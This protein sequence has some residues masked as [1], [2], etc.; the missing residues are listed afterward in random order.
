MTELPQVQSGDQWSG[1]GI[2]WREWGHG[3]PLVMLHGW[4]M[5]SVVF[6]EVA[7]LLKDEFRVIVRT[8]PG[9]VLLQ[10]CLR[11]LLPGWRQPWPIGGNSSI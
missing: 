9:M 8:C 1:G 10:P 6:A 7:E 2:G 11:F 5:S 4:S 3:A